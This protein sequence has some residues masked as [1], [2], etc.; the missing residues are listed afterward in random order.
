MASQLRVDKILPVDGAP[1]G[2]GGGIIQV[3]Q[4]IKK[5]QFT[6]SST[7]SSGGYVDLSFGRLAT[8]FGEATFLP[9]GMNGLVTSG[10]DLTKLRAPGAS[11]RDAIIPTEQI[12]AAFQAGDWGVEAY[13]QFGHDPVQLD[14]MRPGN[15][16]H[17]RSCRFRQCNQHSSQPQ[18]SRQC[19]WKNRNSTCRSC[20]RCSSRS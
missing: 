10:L 14:P 4:T 17:Q 1:T 8:S 9:I 6:T 2:G 18:T 11:I 16:S 20:T 5:D 13:Y 7:V 19:G 3:V 12:V 15:R